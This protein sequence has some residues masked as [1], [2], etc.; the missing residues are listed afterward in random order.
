[1]NGDNGFQS[2]VGVVA[3]H[4]SLVVV[5]GGIV[6]SSHRGPSGSVRDWFRAILFATARGF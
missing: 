1:V 6:E 2:S 5:K 4:H 3:E